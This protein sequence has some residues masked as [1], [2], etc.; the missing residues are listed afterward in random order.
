MTKTWTQL[1]PVEQ[2]PFLEKASYL[3]SRGYIQGK[4]VEDVA[5]TMYK[6]QLVSSE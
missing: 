4:S 2:K 5:E 3:V 6:K 1:L